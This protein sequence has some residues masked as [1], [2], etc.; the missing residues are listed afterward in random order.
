MKIS[1]FY[2]ICAC[3]DTF[4]IVIMFVF[5]AHPSWTATIAFGVLLGFLIRSV[6]EITKL[7]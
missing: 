2:T 7:K 6:K 1:T 5:L 3:L 4:L